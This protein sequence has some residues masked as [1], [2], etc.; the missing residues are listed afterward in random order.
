[1]TFDKARGHVPTLID[2]LHIDGLHT[3]EAVTHDWETFGPLVR[4]GGLVLFHDVN[5]YYKDM[6]KFWK[7]LARRYE[8]Y[9]VPYSQGLGVIRV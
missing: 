6:K 3:W 4:P 9:L 5:S 1:M 8:H 7:I 2:M